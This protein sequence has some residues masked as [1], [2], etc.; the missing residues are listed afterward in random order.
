MAIEGFV[1]GAPEDYTVQ[2]Q[3]AVDEVYN[4]IPFYLSIYIYRS[5]AQS[6]SV[7][8]SPGLFLGLHLSHS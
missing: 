4:A 5:I 2:S 7:A 6:P 3:T 1:Q 8:G